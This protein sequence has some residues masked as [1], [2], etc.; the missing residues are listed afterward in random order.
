M[1]WRKLKNIILLILLA[2]NLALALL[3]GGPALSDYYRESQADREAV[4][5]LERKGIGFGDTMIPDP[6]DLRPMTVDRARE[7]EARLAR[8]MLGED[9][10][11]EARGGEV[12]RYTSSLGVVQFH[13]DGSFWAQ[14]APGAFPT[15]EEP[16]RAALELL[17]RLEFTGETVPLEE[18]GENTLTIRQVWNDAHLFNQQATVLWDSGDIMEIIGGRRLYGEPAVDESRH[19]ITRATA[20]VDFY[21]GLNQLGD[22]CSRV[23]EI[24]PG[25]LS[26][27]SLKRQMA[28]TPVWRIT[29]DT[30]AYQLDLVTGKV[31]RV[32]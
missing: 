10:M 9:A 8:K 25:Y 7:E 6:A 21:N 26:A 32:S 4:A 3:I 12:Y 27:T 30:G 29:T 28:L 14:L 1:E 18:A 2:L 24:V 11:Q 5:F 31:E 15:G 16:E 17:A 13:S 23:D 22:V 20:L 19:T